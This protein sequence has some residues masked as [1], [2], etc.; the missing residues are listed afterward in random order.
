MRMNKKL[1]P[2]AAL[3]KEMRT[4]VEKCRSLTWASDE[5]NAHMARY[6]ELVTVWSTSRQTNMLE[7]MKHTSIV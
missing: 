1:D 5:W 4:I 7:N 3:H 2:A 6:N